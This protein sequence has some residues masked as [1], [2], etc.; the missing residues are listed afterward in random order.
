[1][2][3]LANVGSGKFEGLVFSTGHVVS[4]SALQS[5]RDIQNNDQCP[6]QSALSQ[7]ATNPT[8]TSAGR[9]ADRADGRCL[10]TIWMTTLAKLLAEKQRLLERLQYDP[11]PHERVE[12]E[13]LLGE[14]NGALGLLD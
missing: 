9:T 1:M 11:G 4:V 12:I 10:E 7:R 13:R 2:R 14:I 8:E 5:P 6:R 3:R